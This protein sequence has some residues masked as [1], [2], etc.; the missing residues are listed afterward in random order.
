MSALLAV[1]TALN[2]LL[3]PAGSDDQAQG[4]LGRL[5]VADG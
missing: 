5:W 2:L 3:G 4:E 1:A